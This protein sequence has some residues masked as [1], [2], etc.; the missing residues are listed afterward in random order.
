MAPTLSR[1]RVRVRVRVRDRDRV[2][3]RG[4]GRS[5][6]R[7]RLRVRLAPTLSRHTLSGKPVRSHSLG[8]GGPWVRVRV[9][10]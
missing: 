1:V 9:R 6:G 4:R 3:V 7:G 5:R 10:G 2:R 8:V